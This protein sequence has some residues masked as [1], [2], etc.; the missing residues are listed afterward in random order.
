MGNPDSE[1]AKVISDQFYNN[2]MEDFASLYG[3]ANPSANFEAWGHFSQV[4]WKGTQTVGCYTASCPNLDGGAYT[5]CNYQPEGK[6]VSL[7]W[8]TV[9]LAD[10]PQ[11]TWP[12]PT[13]PTSGILRAGRW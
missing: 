12:A 1:V 9:D 2:E 8:H 7:P 5:V 3:Q 13:A 11:A 4:V 6:K 10:T